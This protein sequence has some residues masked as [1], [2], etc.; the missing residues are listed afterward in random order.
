MP[1]IESTCFLVE[2]VTSDDD[3]KKALQSLYDIFAA[4]DMGQ[5][6][7]EIVSGEP[8]RLWIKHKEGAEPDLELIGEALAGAGDY[9]LIGRES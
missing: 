8:T 5:A 3:T 7:F 2:G 4:H 6:T 1:R 9:R